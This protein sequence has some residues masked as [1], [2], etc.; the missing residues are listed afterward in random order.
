MKATQHGQ[1]NIYIYINKY[2]GFYDIVEKDKQPGRKI[3]KTYFNKRQQMVIKYIKQYPNSFTM[4]KIQV[5]I[6]SLPFKWKMRKELEFHKLL[7]SMK[8]G[9]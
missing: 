4:K 6:T 2:P 3:S 9:G 1:K 7:V 8:I 5:K